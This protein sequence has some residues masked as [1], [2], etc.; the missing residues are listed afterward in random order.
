M[1]NTITIGNQTLTPHGSGVYGTSPSLVVG[2]S[3]AVVNPIAAGQGATNYTSSGASGC[4]VSNTGV[5]TSSAIGACVVKAKY[6]GNSNYNASPE[7]QILSI[8]VGAGV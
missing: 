3:L 6:A 8:T 1:G 4:S 5:V 2:G 7:V